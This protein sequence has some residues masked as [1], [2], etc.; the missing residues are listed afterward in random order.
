MDRKKLNELMAAAKSGD[1]SKLE[2]VRDLISDDDY[3]KALSL[4]N[5]YSHKSEDEIL[6]EL[7]KLKH[8]IPNQ[9]EIIDKLQPFLNAEQKEKL[10]RVLE[11]LEED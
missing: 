7:A 6:K 4:F 9:Q 11:Y 2:D 5:Q 10:Q 1:Y 8:T 3:Q